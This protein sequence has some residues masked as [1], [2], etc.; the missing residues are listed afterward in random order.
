MFLWFFLRSR[1]RAAMS[2][3]AVTAVTG[4]A[5]SHGP[6]MAG[7]QNAHDADGTESMEVEAFYRGRTPGA[8]RPTSPNPP[9]SAGG[10]ARRGAAEQ[11]LVTLRSDPEGGLEHT[12]SLVFD[13]ERRMERLVRRTGPDFE[14][15]SFEQ[16]RNG[17]TLASARGRDVIRLS[18]PAC[19]SRLGGRVRISY[20]S[21]GIFNRY[22]VLELDC[23]RGADD[24]VALFPLGGDQPIRRLRM[25]SRRLLGI[26]IGIDA[27]QVES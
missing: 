25:T 12:L 11:V 1:L 24:R 17:V 26:L 4:I 21:N 20:L 10:A 27:I 22:D 8:S 18:C 2:L 14:T 16:T 9:D 13:A 7:P 5:A 3:L 19:D 6:A 23:R 15:F